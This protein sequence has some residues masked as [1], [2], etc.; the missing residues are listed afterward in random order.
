MSFKVSFDTLFGSV[1]ERFCEMKSMSS[2]L[3]LSMG[4][5]FIKAAH[6]GKNN[7]R[8]DKESF[9]RDGDTMGLI[10]VGNLVMICKV[11]VKPISCPLFIPHMPISSQGD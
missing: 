9:H 8:H 6:Q 5:M 11:S 4:S 2:M 10:L 3:L 1:N 7:G